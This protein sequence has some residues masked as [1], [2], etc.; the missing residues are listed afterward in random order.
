M[1]ENN[2]ISV[3]GTVNDT[4]YAKGDTCLLI[5]PFDTYHLFRIYNNWNTD[6]KALLNLS[7]SGQRLYLVF[8]SKKTEIRIPEYENAGSSYSVDKAN[9]EVLFKITKENANNILAMSTNTFY[10]TRV[11]EYYGEDGSLIYTSGE[12]VIYTG[13][14]ADE[15]R[16]SSSSLTAL[17]NSLKKQLEAANS[18]IYNLN[19]S[20]NEY[21]L[22]VESLL[23]ENQ[24]LQER[25]NTLESENEELQNELSTYENA[26]EFTSVV[27]SD[28]ATY[29]YYKDDVE[30]D[31][32][33]NPLKKKLNKDTVKGLTEV[34]L[35]K[36]LN[37]STLNASDSVAAAPRIVQNG[38]GTKTIY[39]ERRSRK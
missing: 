36:K 18:Q 35:E 4:I 7:D 11:F 25:V 26:T 15:S 29:Q 30:V 13:N 33:G 5:N 16:W 14:W 24:L 9:G 32:N 28:N 6:S 1:M 27:I 3:S 23:E 17:V 2:L 22:Q 20:L 12:E 10:L 31:K 21:K 39:S 8:K 34:Q 37:Q 38:D 19:K